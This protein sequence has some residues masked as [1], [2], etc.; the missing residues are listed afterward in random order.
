MV[1]D[2]SLARFN[3]RLL[4][5]YAQAARVV[6]KERRAQLLV[7]EPLQR[8]EGF[9]SLLKNSY[10]V[11]RN[12]CFHLVAI[13]VRRR[14]APPKRRGH[15]VARPRGALIETSTRTLTR[16]R[17]RVACPRGAMVIPDSPLSDQHP[18]GASPAR[19]GERA[20]RS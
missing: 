7:D 9:A 10:A 2:F 15:H 3:R 17:H 1:P 5:V 20:L 8:G 4:G 11:S 16:R 14:R 18:T 19:G 13:I 12:E 6:E